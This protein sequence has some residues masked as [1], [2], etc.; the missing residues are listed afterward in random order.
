MCPEPI[1]NCI[2]IKVEFRFSQRLVSIRLAGHLIPAE[3]LAALQVGICSFPSGVIVKVI[4]IAEIFNVVNINLR[5]FLHD[6]QTKRAQNL[7]QNL[8]FACHLVP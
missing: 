3:S 6:T 7:F 2:V 5:I 4:V 1:V 8:A